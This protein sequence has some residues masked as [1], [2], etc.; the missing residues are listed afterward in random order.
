MP[1]MDTAPI[2]STDELPPMPEQEPLPAGF[3]AQNL[4][5]LKMPG[6]MERYAAEMAKH[7]AFIK[8]ISS[9]DMSEAQ[10]AQA[11]PK[12]SAFSE[13]T[14]VPAVRGRVMDLRGSKPELLQM[15]GPVDCQLDADYFEASLPGHSDKQ[16]M[17]FVRHGVRSQTNLPLQS[18][19][20]SHLL[21]LANHTADLA[22]DIDRRHKIKYLQRHAC[23]ES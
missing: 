13:R 3:E 23:N 14:R 22:K 9:T 2:D 7:A 5:D 4:S 11:R 15:N 6:Q 20:Q 10:L 1:F 16:I 17:Q 18:V 19:L 8:A 12:P 21:S